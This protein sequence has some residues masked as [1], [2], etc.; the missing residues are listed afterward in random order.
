MHGYAQLFPE[1]ETVD[2]FGKRHD[3][4][5]QKDLRI[6]VPIFVT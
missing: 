5:E 2:L 6:Y 1:T 4:F 3:K